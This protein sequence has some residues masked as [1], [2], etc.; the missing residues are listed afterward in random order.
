MNI[1]LTKIY[2]N[3]KGLWVALNSKWDTVLGADRDIKKAQQQAIKKGHKN[4]IM[5]KVPRKNIAILSL[6]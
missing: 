2:E 1:D 4:P 6:I 5:F 3:Y